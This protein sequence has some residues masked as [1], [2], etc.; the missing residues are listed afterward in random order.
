M[1]LLTRI[2]AIHL[3]AA[4]YIVQKKAIPLVINALRALYSNELL[5]VE[6]LKMLRALSKS[7]EGWK[8]ISEMKGGWQ[9]I[10][11]GTAVGDALIHELPGS[12]NNPGWCI[13]ETPHLP[14][15][16]RRKQ[17]VAALSAAANS[18]NKLKSTGQW[19]AHS[20]RQF[21]GLTMKETKLSINNEEHDTYF[22]V[23]STLDLLPNPREE[24]E[25]WYSRIVLYETE[26]GIQ[27]QEMVYAIMEMRRKKRLEEKQALKEALLED[28]EKE[29][30]KPIYV[31][32]KLYD[33]KEMEESD[34]NLSEQL[35]GV[36]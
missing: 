33:Q 17:Q 6:G 3:P 29:Y 22:E 14:L 34:K 21:M 15:L 26:N 11:Q 16:D 5:Q 10:T 8:Q 32:G 19:T 25:E 12:F 24:K 31:L 20:L 30:V 7:A 1:L 27:V 18:Q 13:G 23:V 28:D 36:V 35:S 2:A 9:A 4:D